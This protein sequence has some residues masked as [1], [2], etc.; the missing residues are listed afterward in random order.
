[1]KVQ[2]YKMECLT[3]LHVGSGD[4]NYNVIDNEVQKD[5]MTGNPVIH[6][7]GIKGAYRDV[8]KNETICKTV[9][10]SKATEENPMSSG[11]YRFTDAYLLSRP[12]RVYGADI[13]NIQVTTVEILNQYI[14]R[15]NFFTG[16]NLAAFDNICFDEEK[17]F[18]TNFWDNNPN[19]KI[20][21]EN[22]GSLS[23]K[24][25]TEEI[26]RAEQLLGSP[27]AIARTFDNYDLPVIAR[28]KIGEAEKSE[29]IKFEVVSANGNQ[30]FNED[31]K[32]AV[33]M[34]AE[35]FNFDNKFDAV[36][37]N[38]CKFLNIPKIEWEKFDVVLTDRSKAKKPITQ[39]LWY[40]ELVPHG[41]VFYFSVIRHDDKNESKD[42]PIKLEGIF[43]FGGHASLGYGYTNVSKISI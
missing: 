26:L 20:E 14:S 41:S 21:G 30:E 36:L 38:G 35:V 13:S 5:P 16:S 39:N 27:F 12:M 3:N 9:F 10:G 43:Q 32:A 2:F 1:M 4:V 34:L 8:Y 24:W 7:S 15:I 23:T 22:T 33:E 42:E 18:Y 37:I 6:S 19:I 29:T 11:I 40:E 25:S 31:Q 28:N 17:E